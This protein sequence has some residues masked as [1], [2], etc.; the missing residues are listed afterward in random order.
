MSLNKN[1]QGAVPENNKAPVTLAPNTVNTNRTNMR[2]PHQ[3]RPDNT[4]M[5]SD[6]KDLS[7]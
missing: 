3:R 4:T 2:G 6:M 5:R 1:A 7:G